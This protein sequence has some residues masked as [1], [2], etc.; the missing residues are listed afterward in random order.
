[1]GRHRKTFFL[2]RFFFNGGIFLVFFSSL[3][4]RGSV[5]RGIFPPKNGSSL[6]FFVRGG[7]GSLFSPVSRQNPGLKFFL[8]QLVYLWVYLS[9]GFDVMR[10]TVRF[11][12]LKKYLCWINKRESCFRSFV[13]FR[14]QLEKPGRIFP[15]K[16]G[17]Q[18]SCIKF[19]SVSMDCL[20]KCY[21]V[22][23]VFERLCNTLAPFPAKT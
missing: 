2:S 1:M 20:P 6:F 15:P 9:V 19:T 7:G 10:Y 22:Y 4:V 11:S 12:S 21:R 16:L 5:F 3:S 14:F 23:W 18:P 13:R 17:Y 8:K